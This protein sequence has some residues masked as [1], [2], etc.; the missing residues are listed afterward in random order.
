MK[1]AG[2]LYFL[3]PGLAL[4]IPTAYAAKIGAPYAPTRLPVVR[5]AFQLIGLNK[6]DFLVDLGAGDGSILLEASKHSARAL[7]YELSPIMWFIIWLRLNIFPLLTK[8]GSA[9][10]GRGV[11]KLANF[12]SQ[13]LPPKTTVVFAFLMPNIM[14]RVLEFLKKQNLP[15]A[16]YFLAYAFPL[17]KEIEPMHV[18]HAKN[19]ARLYVYDWRNIIA[20]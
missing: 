16:K 20:N 11:V 19:C 10:R 9:R 15:Q 3:I 1:I 2:I 7:G 12:Y 4:L 5:K 8:E 18:V 6:N 14:P 17:P 13:Q